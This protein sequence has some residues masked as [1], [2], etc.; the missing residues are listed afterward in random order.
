M[1]YNIRQ[2]SGS[3]F[4]AV[5]K[6][7]HQLFME[8]KNSGHDDD[9]STDWSFSPE[10][11]EYYQK[12]ISDPNYLTLV[13]E[14]GTDIVGYVIGCANNK[15]GYRNKPTGE[16]ENI[17]VT[18]NVRHAG[19]GRNLVDNLLVWLKT[20]GIKRI[21]VTAYS[22]NES[23]INFYDELGFTLESVNLETTV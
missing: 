4:S 3:D 23:A 8:E 10:G 21:V 5:Q 11:V 12:A 20:K 17:Y 7:N 2:A 1:E 6:L 19:I 15:Y 18:E 9:L 22:K 14:I 13:A 16:L